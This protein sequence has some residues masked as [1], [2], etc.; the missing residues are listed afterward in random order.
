[1]RAPDRGLH[2]AHVSQDAPR[3]AFGNK[4]AVF[5]VP[6]LLRFAV[7]GQEPALHENGRKCGVAENA[8]SGPPNPAI[9]GVCATQDA[10][11]HAAG[12]QGVQGIEIISGVPGMALRPVRR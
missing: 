7:I 5:P 9:R 1:L 8:E 2:F 12:Q 10:L 4:V 11:V 6:Q 3:D